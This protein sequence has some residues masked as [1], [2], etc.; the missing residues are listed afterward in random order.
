MLF[1]YNFKRKGKH[2]IF[3]YSVDLRF[4]KISV[5]FSN[6]DFNLLILSLNIIDKSTFNFNLS[7]GD[8]V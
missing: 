1:P 6:L 7:L 3:L 8:I 2:T 4:F 5:F